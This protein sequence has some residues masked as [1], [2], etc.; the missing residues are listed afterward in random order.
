MKAERA[1]LLFKDIGSICVGLGGIVWQLKVGPDPVV[2]GVLAAIASIPLT[3]VAA[4]R[5]NGA[6]STPASSSPSPPPSEQERS[7]AP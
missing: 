5:S 2:M 1:I 3:N 7:S 6:A 4:L